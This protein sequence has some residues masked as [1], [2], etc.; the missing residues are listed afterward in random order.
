M[1]VLVVDADPMAAAELARTFEGSPVQVAVAATPSEAVSALEQNAFHAVLVSVTSPIGEVQQA[2]AALTEKFPHLALG[3]L[4][5]SSDLQTAQASGVVPA[6]CWMVE[7]PLTPEKLVAVLEEMARAQTQPADPNE[8]KPA[9]E[10][11]AVPVEPAA[12]LFVGKIIGPFHVGRKL[13]AD[14]WGTLHEALQVAVNRPVAVKILTPALSGDPDKVVQFIAIAGAMAKAQNPY[15]TAVYE[16]GE[17]NGVIYF[18]REHV[19]G[20]NLKDHVTRGRSLN[21]EL[22]LRAVLNIGDALNYEKK[23]QIPHSPLVQEQVLIPETGAPKLLNNVTVEGEET[24]AGETDEIQ[25][26]GGMLRKVVAGTEDVSPE[27]KALLEK[28]E[29]SSQG[30]YADWDTL[31]RDANQLDLHRRALRA[32]R[33]A[34]S[35]TAADVQA[36]KA[37]PWIKRGGI[38]AVAALLVVLGGWYF[39][40]WRKG[41]GAHDLETMLEVP[42]GS[43]IYQGGEQTSLPTFYIDKYEVTIKQYRK[44][45]E[46]WRQNKT[47]IREHDSQKSEKEHTPDQWPAILAAIRDGTPLN[48]GRIY[49]N[50]PVFNV[51]YLDVWA[52]AKWA[53]KR[54]PTE[55]EWEKAAR[56]PKGNVY[57]WGNSPNPRNANTGADLNPNYSHPSFGKIDGFGVWAPVGAVRGDR[58]SYGVMDMAGNVSEWTDSLDTNPDFPAAPQ[59]PVIRGGSWASSDVRLVIRDLRQSKFKRSP[60][61]G[62]RCVS[63]RPPAAQ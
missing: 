46:A 57:P 32:V 5:K 59:V 9:L 21:E 58:S 8:P 13:A 15:I 10:T 1:N 31:L 48:G 37:T 34:S 49:E 33:P 53:G 29:T 30:G 47:A 36:P 62:F 28:M 4:G 7:Q 2:V 19:D 55:L 42:G 24:S 56:G 35:R 63:D 44:F 23:H 40:L 45:L 26:L 38:A 14:Y 12:D 22:V 60:Q 39:G 25:R 27:F 54:L 50:T 11:A 52:Y 16:A 51:D 41:I 61:I 3:L 43:F 18:A 17:E 6:N 20:F